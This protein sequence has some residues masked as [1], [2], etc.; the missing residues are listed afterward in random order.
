M[1]KEKKEMGN[2]KKKKV[3]IEDSEV[4]KAKKQ[5][6]QTKIMV[7][8]MII[9]LTSVFLTYWIAQKRKTFEYKG[10]KFYKE[11]EGHLVFYKS[12]LGYVTWGGESVPFVLKLRDDPRGLES[13][14]VEGKIK[15]FRTNTVISLSPAIADC[16]DTVRIMVDFSMTLGAFGL[17]TSAATTDETYSEKNNVPLITCKDAHRKTVIVM[18]EADE[19]KIVKTGD[20]YIMQIKNCEVQESFEKFILEFISNSMTDVK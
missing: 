20:C 1:V 16:K 13:I 3:K 18:E 7:V 4:K 8:I 9:L 10:M 17:K 15:N 19:T 2:E 11:K 14:K 5:N 12:M 6:R